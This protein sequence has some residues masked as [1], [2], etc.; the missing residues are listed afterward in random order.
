MFFEQ[1]RTGH[2]ERWRAEPALLSVVVPERLLDRVELAV[3]F[4]SFDGPN[5][6]ALRLDGQRRAGIDRLAVHDHRAGAASGAVADPL[7]AG[8]VQIVAQ[9]VEQRDA[10]FDAH[11]LRGAVDV[12]CDVDLARAEYW[13]FGPG[14]FHFVFAASD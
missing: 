3:L 7:G 10:R 4:E 11:L 5:L 12:E 9:R 6:L 13:D 8:D 1:R 2:D 14:G